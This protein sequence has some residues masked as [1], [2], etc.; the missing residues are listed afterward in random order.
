MTE[1]KYSYKVLLSL[2]E[3]KDFG[4][5]AEWVSHLIS[6]K[7]YSLALGSEWGR[8]KGLTN[9]E[10]N[11]KEA[12]SEIIYW[13][14]DNEKKD[15]FW[16]QAFRKTQD[17]KQLKN[18]ITGTR[19]KAYAILRAIHESGDMHR[20]ESLR[21]HRMCREEMKK[22]EKTFLREKPP[23]DHND[24]YGLR[25]WPNIQKKTWLKQGKRTPE[26]PKRKPFPRNKVMDMGPRTLPFNWG[27]VNEA[28]RLALETIDQ[29]SMV[30][31]LK[32]A[33]VE[34]EW[35]VLI[36]PSMIEYAEAFPTKS[37]D[38]YIEPYQSEDIGK[39]SDQ[40]EKA[41]RTEY[42]R[43]ALKE[44]ISFWEKLDETFK[45]VLKERV[46]PRILEYQSKDILTLHGLAEKHG[47]THGT[48]Q[49]RDKDAIKLLKE[50]LE[51][52][53]RQEKVEI[54]RNLKD[55]FENE[56]LGTLLAIDETNNEEINRHE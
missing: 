49:T 56:D 55:F 24:Y 2:H 15:L 31:Q 9:Q 30:K 45:I 10:D 35:F 48:W 4:A 29:Y 51:G 1:S 47:K 42:K 54:L 14:L 23:K 46:F 33:L 44:I 38:E 27:D 6:P 43:W 8:N 22:D 5:L 12:V 36:T 3:K 18:K 13:F 32:N 19:G 50:F 17:I 21:L 52:Y 40:V 26:L 25:T 20:N 28:C 37:G 7:K 34:N 16:K 11:A 53:N 39:H 41:S